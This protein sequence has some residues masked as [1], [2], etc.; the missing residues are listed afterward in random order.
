MFIASTAPGQSSARVT[1]Y[2]I[3]YDSLR[4][5]PLGGAFIAIAGAARS[6]TSDAHGRFRFDS[7]AP[8]T[9]VFTMQHDAL[10]SIGMSGIST[11][12]AVTDG[13][14]TVNVSIHSF[15][16]IW[17]TSCGGN[18]PRDSG[19]VFGTVRVGESQSPAAA[20]VVTASWVDVNVDKSN[21]MKQQRW[22]LEV[23]ADASG[24]YRLCGVPTTVGLRV[25]ARSD[26]AVTGLVDLLPRDLRVQRRDLQLGAAVGEKNGPRGTITGV[27]NGDGG[28]PVAGARISTDGAPEARSD[29]SGRFVVRDVPTGTRQV[30][31][32]AIGMVPVSVVVDVSARDTATAIVEVRRVTTLDPV[33]VKATPVRQKMVAAIDERRKTG[34]GHYA[35]STT[36]G[37]H[38]RILSVFEEMPGVRVDGRGVVRF[39]QGLGTC[40]ANVWIDGF[41]SDSTDTKWL[42]PDEVAVVEVYPRVMSMP[43]EFMVRRARGAPCGSIVIW[44]KR[45]MP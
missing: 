17:R 4:G 19:M 20:A 2:G 12:V 6:A 8:G 7:I 40:V 15:A 22:T 5:V 11:K 34:F 38:G 16:E 35:D 23:R 29:A 33:K 13:R 18:A 36:I 27:V 39:G 43:P 41:R 26:S 25:Q 37:A 32:I 3:A 21:G 1:G 28:Q 30:D 14:D 9:Y 44:T 10:D 42:R 31:V 24:A 45:A